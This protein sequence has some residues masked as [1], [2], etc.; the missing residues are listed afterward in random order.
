ML[1]MYPVVLVDSWHGDH[2][3]LAATRE[4]R[5]CISDRALFHPV[6][7][8]GLPVETNFTHTHSRV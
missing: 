6:T 3:I 4:S 7:S 2:G 1:S 5:L 8:H